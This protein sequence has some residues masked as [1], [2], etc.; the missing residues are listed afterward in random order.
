MKDE[1][2]VLV[3]ACGN[4]TIRVAVV[5]GGA[6]MQRAML[7]HGNGADESLAAELRAVIGGMR[8][9]APAR[10]G[11]AS[12]L[13]AVLCSVVPELALMA[14]DACY[15]LD[16]PLRRVRAADVT[17]FDLR[18]DPPE[19]LGE[20]RLC[21]LVALRE[22]YGYPSVAVDF[23][24]ATTVNVLDARG[25][26]A[27]GWIAPGIGTSFAALAASTA[28]LPDA[29]DGGEAPLLGSTTRESIRAGILT[30]GRLGMGGLIGELQGRFGR[31]IPVIATGGAAAV[32]HAA[33]LPGS[34]LDDDLVL[35]GAAVFCRRT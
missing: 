18:Y 12:P 32:H 2:S 35:L 24:T 21:C 10:G 15:E 20:D 14:E 13:R 34:V 27:G 19:A 3:I 26:F 16:L 6:V 8:S 31:T 9:A 5:E 17:W 30:Q 1:G 29:R 25:D 23:G 11:A 7:P 28:L 33:L 22:K 4:S